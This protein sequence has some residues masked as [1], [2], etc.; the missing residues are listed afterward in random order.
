MNKR[1]ANAIKRRQ[2]AG[3]KHQYSANWKDQTRYLNR[4]KRMAKD[5]FKGLPYID[6]RDFIRK[7]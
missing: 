5:D 7:L 2:M 3:Y 4:E 6:W 1:K